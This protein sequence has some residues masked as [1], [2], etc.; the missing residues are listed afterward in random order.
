MDAQDLIGKQV[1]IIDMDLYARGSNEVAYVAIAVDAGDTLVF[2]AY[3][4]PARAK[5]ALTLRDTQP[6]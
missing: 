1:T 4:D 5:A 3:L 2:E 6:S